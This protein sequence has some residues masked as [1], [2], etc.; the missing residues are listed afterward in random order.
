[1]SRRD[2]ALTQWEACGA[3]PFPDLKMPTDQKARHRLPPQVAP[4]WRQDPDL[5]A[6]HAPFRTHIARAIDL[7]EAA[8]RR[9]VPCGVVV[10]DAWDLAEDVVQVVA[11]RRKA[12]ISR[13]NKHRR[14]ETASVRR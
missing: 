4:V 13:L 5:R 10:F 14:L 6:R 3:T 8:I 2:E 9:Q 12:W 7:V 1:M 11:R